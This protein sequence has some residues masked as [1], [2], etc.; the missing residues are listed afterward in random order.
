[1]VMPVRITPRLSYAHTWNDTDLRINYQSPRRPKWKH[2]IV[3][4]RRQ[5]LERIER[6]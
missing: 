4:E 1:M 2:Q 3:D 6:I 5:I